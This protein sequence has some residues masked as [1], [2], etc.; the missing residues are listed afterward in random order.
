MKRYLCAALLLSL[1][2]LLSGCPLVELSDCHPRYWRTCTD[3]G[4]PDRPG[5]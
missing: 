5:R 1:L 2:S 4:R 3:N